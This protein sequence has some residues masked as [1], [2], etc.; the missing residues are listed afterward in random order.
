MKG[1]SGCSATYGGSPYRKTAEGSS[2]DSP[3]PCRNRMGGPPPRC[4][5]SAGAMALV[6]LAC[7]H[8]AW[9]LRSTDK[10]DLPGEAV[11]N[12]AI[13]SSQDRRHDGKRRIEGLARLNEKLEG[14]PCAACR[15]QRLENAILAGEVAIAREKLS[16]RAECRCGKRRFLLEVRKVHVRRKIAKSERAINFPAFES[17]M[18][19]VGAQCSLLDDACK[20]QGT[21]PRSRL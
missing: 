3:S 13:F 8:C 15:M 11:W 9:T 20:A 17:L 16:Q 12:G 2:P 6:P 19:G 10:P 4:L 1:K 5:H 21:C 14:F 18:M 7:A